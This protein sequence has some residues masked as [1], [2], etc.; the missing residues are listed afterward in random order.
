[1]FLIWPLSAVSD[2]KI[3]TVKAFGAATESGDQQVRMNGKKFWLCL[4]SPLKGTDKKKELQETKNYHKIKSYYQSC[5]NLSEMCLKN[6]GPW[7]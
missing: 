6:Q 1:M 7:S 2:N 3:L 5:C 4:R